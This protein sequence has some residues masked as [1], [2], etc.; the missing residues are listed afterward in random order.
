[1]K[2]Y[3]FTLFVVGDNTFISPFLWCENFESLIFCRPPRVLLP[4]IIITSG[5]RPI[6]LRRPPHNL[7][8]TAK[9]CAEGIFITII[10]YICSLLSVRL[11]PYGWSLSPLIVPCYLPP[12]YLSHRPV[13]KLSFH[14]KLLIFI[15]IS[16]RWKENEN[17][18]RFLISHK[19][20]TFCP[21]SCKSQFFLLLLYRLTTRWLALRCW[22]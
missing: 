22:R 16:E 18:N 7:T 15:K 11:Q 9:R 13:T 6:I 20:E 10:L 5:D 21:F 17:A 1:M 8:P 3:G 2:L 12:F 19:S 14:H 4:T